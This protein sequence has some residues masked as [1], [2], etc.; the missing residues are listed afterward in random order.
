MKENRK[1]ETQVGRPA[2]ISRDEIAESALS[3]GLDSMT[4]KK[5]AA[6]L[7][8]DHSS[9]Y[10]HIKN[11]DDIIFMALDKA[12][13]QLDLEAKTGD[14]KLYL[15]HIAKSLWDMY[16]RYKG[17]A[18]TVRSSEQTP[19][20]FIEAFAKACSNLESFGFS[21]EDA[22]LIVDSIA[23]MTADSASLWQRLE[24]ADASGNKG[25]EQLSHSW[26]KAKKP[27][28]GKHIDHVLKIISEDPQLW[29][30][31]KLDL[32]IAGAEKYYYR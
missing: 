14:W 15:S 22:A 8:V 16:S 5:I 27:D 26:E 19:T 12:I 7:G 3:L 23:D 25:V 9:L 17:L 21:T 20:T 32:I 29:W 28:T 24:T 13:V 1:M 4:L 10:R 31:K 11:R 18:A 2:R 6:H 30:S